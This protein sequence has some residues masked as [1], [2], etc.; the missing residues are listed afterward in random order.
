MAELV[1]RNLKKRNKGLG[2]IPALIA[3]S[4]VLASCSSNSA[5]KSYVLAE[6]L[7][8]DGKYEAA[9]SEFEK[10]ARKDPGGKIGLQA[11]Y[12]AAM[13]EAYFLSKYTDAVR[14]F[15]RYLESNPDPEEAWEA[16]KQLAEILY[17]K[18]DQYDQAAL[19]YRTLLAAKPE[20]P[21]APE[22]LFR[23]GK[24]QFFLWQFEDAVQTY[25]D[26]QDR[27]PDDPFSEKAAFE[28]GATY[29]TRGEQ[30]PAVSEK[31][32]G[33]FSNTQRAGKSY[34]LAIEA[35]QAFLTKYPKSP[36][37]SQARFGIASCLEE[38]DQL[39]AASALYR[40]LLSSYP[41]PEVIQIKLFRIRERKAQRSR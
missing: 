6:K 40:T 5:K 3:F 36:L 39:D 38:L 31:E 17:S 22:F 16:R 4:V 30:S 41:S 21:S 9:V 11:L 13:T 25:R 1:Q 34:Q 18:L 29:Y 27:F 19:V 7:W 26:L 14:K 35:Y 2:V 33:P 10:V 12:R 37:T 15:N 23:L 20:S 24:S 28:I 8:T 32:S